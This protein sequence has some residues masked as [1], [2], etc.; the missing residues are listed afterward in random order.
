[1][2]NE[3]KKADEMLKLVDTAFSAEN[4]DK[5]HGM[6]IADHK[7][8]VKVLDAHLKVMDEHL[9][10]RLNKRDKELSDSI[11]HDVADYLK[12]QWADISRTLDTQTMALRMQTELVI[13][14][15]ED[16][17]SVKLKQTVDEDKIKKLEEIGTIPESLDARLKIVE[18]LIPIV[19]DAKVYMSPKWTVV[20]WAIVIVIGSLLVLYL[21]ERFP[22]M[23]H[24]IFGK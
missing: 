23:I 17:T 4:A 8:I 21:G 13:K 9:D 10:D 14:I 6:K 2:S 11:G 15:L 24:K 12:I 19:E 22:E 7:L 3:P 16:I 20:R 18:D 1:M 5:D